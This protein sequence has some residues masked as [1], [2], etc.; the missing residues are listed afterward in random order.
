MPD[1]LSSQ[2]LLWTFKWLLAL[3]PDNDASWNYAELF[4][5]GAASSSTGQAPPPPWLQQQQQQQQ[6]QHVPQQ[7]P[8]QPPQQLQPPQLLSGP[9]LVQQ[10]KQTR[11]R[12]QALLL[13]QQ[14]P[15]GSDALE[16]EFSGV[17]KSVMESCT[18]DAISVSFSLALLRS[19]VL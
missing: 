14:Q 1:I 17:V 9:D 6:H 8:Q 10:L 2:H 13:H 12:E 15:G 11:L 19:L 3:S 4:F 7:P 16:E 18:K 5:L